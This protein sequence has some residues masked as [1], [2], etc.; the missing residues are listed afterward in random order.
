MLSPRDRCISTTVASGWHPG[1]CD[2]QYYETGV[3]IVL[4]V[5]WNGQSEQLFSV[6]HLVKTWKL[7]EYTWNNGFRDQLDMSYKWAPFIL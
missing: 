7:P 2:K 6:I 4:Q 1:E 3:P 5:A